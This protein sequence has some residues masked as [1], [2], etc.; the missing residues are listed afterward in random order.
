MSSDQLLAGFIIYLCIINGAPLKLRRTAMNNF[1]AY[2]LSSNFNCDVFD[3]ILALSGLVMYKNVVNFIKYN[4]IKPYNLPNVLYF[5]YLI[6]YKNVI[7]A[8]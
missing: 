8:R 4:D 5:K 1:R 7:L 3:N 2:T 6:E